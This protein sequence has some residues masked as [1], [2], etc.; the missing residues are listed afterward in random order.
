MWSSRLLGAATLCGLLSH[1]RADFGDQGPTYSLSYTNQQLY[2]LSCNEHCDGSGEQ[3]NFKL[4]LDS[5]VDLANPAWDNF[6]W[7]EKLSVHSATAVVPNSVTDDSQS[8][9]YLFGGEGLA[10][11][12]DTLFLAKYDPKA[13]K[14]D[15][16][17]AAGSPS[18]RMFV[19]SVWSPT[20]SRFVCYGGYWPAASESNSTDAKATFYSDLFMFDPAEKQWETFNQGIVHPPA[21]AGHAAV[22][23]DDR[24]MLVVG[25]ANSDGPLPTKQVYMIDT[26]NTSRGW[27]TITTVGDIPSTLVYASAF[28]VQGKVVMYGSESYPDTR[29]SDAIFVLDPSQDTW[30]WYRVAMTPPHPAGDFTPAALVG[31]YLVTPVAKDGNIQLGSLQAY[32]LATM[33]AVTRFQL[34][35]ATSIPGDLFDQWVDHGSSLGGGTIAGIVIGCIAG[36]FVILGAA[37]YFA[38]HRSGR[39]MMWLPRNRRH[40]RRGD[41]VVKTMNDMGVLPSDV[42]VYYNT[43]D[44]NQPVIFTTRR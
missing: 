27:A 2:L 1:A 23:L 6:T 40:M 38:I 31:R 21:A 42:D 15:A 18:H 35:T 20:A 17:A 5:D 33:K 7:Q 4:S 32:D 36:V 34:D 9:I 43:D 16:V 3:R 11:S 12:Q 13:D 29:A 10:K 25:G 39:R 8:S 30:K 22:M 24:R 37:Y 26:A 44:R 14:L 19:S 28:T 41:T